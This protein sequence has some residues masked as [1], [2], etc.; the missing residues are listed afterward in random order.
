[1]DDEYD[2]DNWPV[3]LSNEPYLDAIKSTHNVQRLPAYDIKG[4]LIH[5]FDYEEKLAGAIARVCFSIVHFVVRQKHIYN[6]LVRDITI[7]RPP[8][9]IATTSLKHILHPKKKRRVV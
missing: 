9:T 3:S 1:M 5:P 8:I 7:V 6:A 2:I 4:D